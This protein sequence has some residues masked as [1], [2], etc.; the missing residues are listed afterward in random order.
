MSLLL[1][2]L[3]QTAN[4]LS[5]GW[6][7]ATYRLCNSNNRHISQSGRSEVKVTAKSVSGESPW[8]TF[9][10]FPLVVTLCKH[11]SSRCVPVDRQRKLT[12]LFVRA[13]ILP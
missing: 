13:L 5:P 11:A 4:F 3:N 8:Q 6:C 7:E 12:P 1:K 9:K 2:K 10:Q